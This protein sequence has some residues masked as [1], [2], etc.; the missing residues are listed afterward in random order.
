MKKLL[1]TLAAFAL[2][3]AFGNAL[4]ATGLVNSKHNMSS[5]G[6]NDVKSNSNQLCVYCHT[7]HNAQMPSAA[8]GSVGIWNHTM[9]AATYI[10]R[11]PGSSFAGTSAIQPNSGNAYTSLCMSCHDGTVALGDLHNLNAVG[12]LAPTFSGADVSGSGMMT[13]PY[14]IGTNLTNAHPIEVQYNITG[15]TNII[16]QTDSSRASVYAQGTVT[17]DKVTLY[18]EA[19][20]NG[21]GGPAQKYYIECRSCHD[22]HNSKGYTNLLS[23]DNSIQSQ[24][25]QAC[26]NK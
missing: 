4:A 10:T 17:G 24:M 1:L 21:T 6:P 19:P 8:G 3:V 11:T 9:S 13:G 22:V 16:A 20:A 26:H 25:C 5:G 7:P 14:S 12:G 2:I 23:M 18:A 15:K